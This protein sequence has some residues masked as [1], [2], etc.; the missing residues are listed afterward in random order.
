MQLRKHARSGSPTLELL[1]EA[2]SA[3]HADNTKTPSMLTKRY[4]SVDVQGSDGI[5]MSVESTTTSPTIRLLR[6][7]KG[8]GSS[9]VNQHSFFDPPQHGVVDED[10]STDLSLIHI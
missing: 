10:E 8:S 9:S 1:Q 7:Y 4:S 5:A 6:H 2:D 3:Y